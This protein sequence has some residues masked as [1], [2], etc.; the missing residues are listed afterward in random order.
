VECAANLLVLR[1][2]IIEG[3]PVDGLA[4]LIVV[5]KLHCVYDGV[6]SKHKRRRVSVWVIYQGLGK[7]EAI[8]LI[9]ELGVGLAIWC[10]ENGK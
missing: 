5:K 2:Q 8:R 4:L 10:D 7:V 3:S 6:V 1:D 9:V